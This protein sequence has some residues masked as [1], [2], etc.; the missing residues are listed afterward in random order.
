MLAGLHSRNSPSRRACLLN[1][2]ED[3]NLK[4]RDTIT[5]I[6]KSKTLINAAVDTN[7]MVEN[8]IQI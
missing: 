1:R 4:I 3:K 6:N 5:E 7:L 8:V 2:T